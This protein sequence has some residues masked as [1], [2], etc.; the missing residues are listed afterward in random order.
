MG[1]TAPPVPQSPVTTDHAQAYADA[2]AMLSAMHQQYVARHGYGVPAASALC[3]GS[4][5]LARVARSL[6]GSA[7]T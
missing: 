5:L 6:H 4:L 7:A 2:A 1:A 3:L